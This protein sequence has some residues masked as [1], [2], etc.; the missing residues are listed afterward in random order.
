MSIPIPENNTYLNELLSKA[1]EKRQP[2]SGTFELTNRCNLSCMMCYISESACNNSVMEKELTAQEWIDIA[3][4]ASKNGMVFLLL[5]GGEIFL[6]N[7][8]FDIYEPLR[9]MGVVLTLFTNGTLISKTTAK[10]LSK[11]PPNKLEI[12]LY[13]ATSKT[14]ETVTGSKNGFELCCSGMENLLSAGIKPVIKTTITRQNLHEHEDIK[15]MAKEW[16]LPFLSAWLLT[17]RVDGKFSSFE[18]SLLSHEDIFNLELKDKYTN[19]RWKKI[20]QTKSAEP[21][22]EIFYCKAGKSSFIINSS[23]EMNVC[24]DL[25]LPAAKVLNKGFNAA[26]EEVKNYVEAATH[27]TSS[28]ST[29]NAKEY[30]N[31]CPARSYLETKHLD[32]PVPYL[33]DISFKRKDIYESKQ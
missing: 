11:L 17:K 30:C 14:Y 9:K 25:P 4:Q 21:K 6:R 8:F 2:V 1:A 13:G 7:D 26:W 31:T 3:G 28:C 19:E 12:T 18:D 29:C 22:S 27:K 16:G 23:G 10:R 32:E 20:A 33:C 24:A 5:T 15:K